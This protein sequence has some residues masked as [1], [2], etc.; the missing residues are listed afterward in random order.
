MKNEISGRETQK[1]KIIKSNTFQTYLGTAKRFS[2]IIGDEHKIKASIVNHLKGLKKF[3]L[4]SRRIGLEP[5]KI[6]YYFKKLSVEYLKT[7]KQEEKR[8]I[9]Q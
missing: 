4:K 3:K 7:E 1:S 5:S 6:N 8:K 9:H 2:R